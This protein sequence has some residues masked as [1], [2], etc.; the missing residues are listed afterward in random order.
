MFTILFVGDGSSQALLPTLDS[1]TVKSAESLE[2]ALGQMEQEAADLL[3]VSLHDSQAIPSAEVEDFLR[4]DSLQGCSALLIASAENSG[5][6]L[7]PS[8]LESRSVEVIRE[9]DLDSRLRTWLDFQKRLCKLQSRIAAIQQEQRATESLVQKLVHDMKSPLTV[10]LIELGMLERWWEKGK[11][12]RFQ[13]G[14]FRLTQN[15]EELIEMIQNLLDINR[16]RREDLK[17][18]FTLLGLASVLREVLDS[19]PS[20]LKK[21]GIR[22]DSDLRDTESPLSLDPSMINRA[23]VNLLKASARL[24]PQKGRILL[25]ARSCQDQMVLQVECQGRNIASEDCQ[26]L[27]DQYAHEQWRALGLDAGSGIGLKVAKLLIEAQ[28]GRLSVKSPPGKGT[29]FVIE[30]PIRPQKS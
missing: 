24:C 21:R 2:A 23:L 3:I 10:M 28:Q 16:I 7:D 17:V 11:A 30:L 4:M 20:I 6:G 15:C 26:A 27:L 13:D 29:T 18:R 1:C 9:S 19:P 5:L 12:E 14:I 25:S 8:I 22:I